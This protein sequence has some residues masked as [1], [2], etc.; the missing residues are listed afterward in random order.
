MKSFGLFNNKCNH[1]RALFIV[2]FLVLAMSGAGRVAE[3][4]TQTLYLN[5]SSGVNI[6]TSGSALNTNTSS[7][8]QT[9]AGSTSA[10]AF[11]TLMS[12]NNNNTSSSMGVSGANRNNWYIHSRTYYNRAFGSAATISANV[13]GTFYLMSQSTTERFRF[14]LLDF[15]PANGNVTTI[16]TSDDIFSPSTTTPTAVTVDFKNTL[17]TLTS[18]HY[19]AIEIDFYPTTNGHFGY[20]SYNSSSYPS[21]INP[22]IQFTVKTTAGAYGTITGPTALGTTSV[23][24]DVTLAGY[25]VTADPGYTIQSLTVDGAPVTGANGFGSYPVTFPTFTTNH[26]INAA[27]TVITYP[28]SVT[29]NSNGTISLPAQ[30]LTWPPASVSHPLPAG[31][32]SFIVTPSTNYAIQDIKVNG[33]SQAVPGGQITPMQ[34]DLDIPDT[35]SIEATFVRIYTVTLTAGTGGSFDLPSPQYVPSGQPFTIEIMPDPNYVITAITDDA[36]T[37]ANVSPYTIP[38]VTADHAIAAS[39]TLAHT[40]HAS[41]GSNG[42]IN[43]I[44]DTLVGHGT[45]RSFSIEPNVGYR[46][47]DV[48]VDGSSVGAVATYAFTNVT[49]DHTISAVFSVAP[50]LY[51]AIPPYISTVAP[52]SVMLMLSVESPMQGVANPTVNCAAN[53]APS[54]INNYWCSKATACGNDA[55]GCYDNTKNYY[56]YFENYKCYSYSGSGASGLFAPSGPAANHQCGTAGTPSTTWSGNFLN[57]MSMTAVDSFRR[58]FTGGNR[59]V[60]NSGGDTVLLAARLDANGWFPDWINISDAELYTPYSGARY[61]K[62]EGVGIGFGVCSAT[63]T[64]CTVTS[65]GSGEA[66][67]PVAG[68]NAEAVF[69]LRIK[70][71]DSTGGVESRCNTTTNKPEG[72]IQKN[73][74]KMRFA[75]I[76]YLSDNSKE[77]DGGVLRAPMKWISPTIPSGMKYHDGTTVLTCNTTAGCTNPEREVESDGLFRNNPDGA[78]GVNSGLINYINKFAYTSGYKSADPISEMYYEVVRYFRNLG[79][80][81]AGTVGVHN[82]S[83]T[84][85]DTTF[86]SGGGFVYYGDSD[87]THTW[88]WRDQSLYDCS[89]YYVIAVNDANPWLDKRIPGSG[90]TG[91]YSGGTAQDIYNDWCGATTGNCDDDFNVDVLDWTNRVGQYEGLTP[92]LLKVGCVWAS[93]RDC[94]TAYDASTSP[95]TGFN[96]SQPKNVGTSEFGKIISTFPDAS[97]KYNSYNIAGLAYYAHMTELRPDLTALT[98]GKKRNLTTFMIDTQEPQTSMLVGSPNMLYL[99][100]KFGG[101][102]DKDGDGKPYKSADCDLRGATH[103]ASCCDSISATPDDGCSEWITDNAR[104]M[105]DNYYF[106]SNGSAVDTGLNKAF[107]SILT[108][109]NSGTASASANSR[110]GQRGANLIQAMFYPEWPNGRSIKWL[111]EVQSLWFYLD[112]VIAYSAILE[113]TDGNRELDLQQD[114]LPNADPFLTK[115][116]WRAG[117]LL[118]ARTAASR[119]I[120]TLLDSGQPLTANANKFVD[121]NLSSTPT[122]LKTLMDASLLTN[123]QAQALINYIRGVDSSSYRSRKLT[124]TSTTG[125]THTTT[126]DGIWKLGDVINSTPQVQ[127]AQAL[128]SYHLLY[129]DSSYTSFIKSSQYIAR[130][131]VYV[132]ANDGMLHAF[133]LGLVSSVTDSVHRF[134]YARIAVT[135]DIGKEEWAFIPKNALP[136]LK[137]TAEKTYGHQYIVDGMSLLVDASIN[138]YCTATNYWKCLRKTTLSGN[139]YLPDSS[140]W[141]TVLVGSMGLGGATRNGDCSETLAHDAIASNNIDCIKAPITDKGFSSYF[142][143]DVTEPTSP[144]HMW[145]FSD[146]DLASEDKQ[147]EVSSG[148]NTYCGLGLTTP[149]VEIVRINAQSGTPAK[150]DKTLNG[151]W[152]AIMASGPTGTID[153]ASKQFLGRSDQNLRLFVVDLNS[154]PPFTRCTSAGQEGCNYWIFDTGKKYAFASSIAS[155]ATDLDQWNSTLAGYYSDDVVYVTFTKATLDG[156]SPTPYP[157]A[158][159]KGGVLRLITKNDPDPINWFVST[160]IDDIGPVTSSIGKLR[161]RNN[162]KFWIFFGEGRYFFQG[163]DLNTRRRFFG[164]ADPCYNYDFAHMNM[165]SDTLAK[166]PTVYDS[167]MGVS[168]DSKLTDQTT[169][170]NGTVEVGKKG[171]YISMNDVVTDVTGAERVV[172]DVNAA[173][174]GI[175]FFT[176]FEPNYGTC[177]PNGITSMWA[178]KYTSGGVPAHEG[179]K[180]KVPMQT[181]TGI[182]SMVDLATAFT[183]EGGRKLNSSLSPNGMSPKG[184]IKPLLQPK[185]SKKYLNIHER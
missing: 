154:T 84:G 179:M 71:C 13:A 69:S 47:Q 104:Q 147:C 27:F 77:R 119:T 8:P 143:L 39:F 51:C 54:D 129:S 100:A 63:K 79:P 6:K 162:S 29:A 124:H 146:I 61:F 181:S 37:V 90:Y 46:I 81:S 38:S 103:D 115:A 74:D 23:D 78:S 28:L 133:R 73:M 141:K 98:N 137:N 106:A 42:M 172:S 19:L 139:S 92:G 184:G 116:I 60:D 70:A 53:V 177:D 174:N 157:T 128:N 59:T 152:F 43:P 108:S 50:T 96:T 32:Y 58:A 83:N 102:V 142:A 52:P 138:N 99:A 25:T 1:G 183:G 21:R 64:S 140:S 130:N 16:S 105:P 117:E 169:T 11:Q 35:T 30:S 57:W 56:G 49:V 24:L 121:T 176:T 114:H 15:N 95:Y 168:I 40:I 5:A 2:L 136:Y 122:S 41:A 34:L 180:G 182:I 144:K 109:T 66:Q 159:N 153:T 111:G 113:D 20:V 22:E 82:N 156:S 3:A 91:S 135:T 101:F 161:D 123:T 178:V 166:C 158:W 12:K 160:L 145:E 93:G 89:Q 48:V 125:T 67:W 26:T 31:T 171:W 62:R 175:V 165:L 9:K 17:T 10:V 45:S 18:G 97:D 86:P 85:F 87:K 4:A 150:A 110:S 126:T 132:G 185:P 94:R 7:G 80:S 151:R 72:T 68:T 112:P 149:G 134:R 107:S 127:P 155:S 76:S 170:P 131:M 167:S 173:T 55:L 118:H 148:V 164:I 14:K 33:I 65:T 44:G 163:D 120:Y 88:G 75:L 36:S